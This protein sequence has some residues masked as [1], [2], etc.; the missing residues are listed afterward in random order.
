M[1]RAAEKPA[2]IARKKARA[3]LGVFRRLDGAWEPAGRSARRGRLSTAIDDS[4]RRARAARGPTEASRRVRGRG[5]ENVLR[6]LPPAHL[7]CQW[8]SADSRRARQGSTEVLVLARVRKGAVEIRGLV[9]LADPFHTPPLSLPLPSPVPR[10]RSQVRAARRI[11][12][13]HN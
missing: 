12:G 3:G 10:E 13:A 11:C 9:P 6:N 1:L 5:R 7:E 2:A 8:N 4:E